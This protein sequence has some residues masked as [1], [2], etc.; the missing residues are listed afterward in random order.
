MFLKV[1]TKCSVAVH[2]IFH[3][4]S[5][6]TVV[7]PV[8]VLYLGVLFRPRGIDPS[9]RRPAAMTGREDSQVLMIH[10]RVFQEQQSSQNVSSQRNAVLGLPAPFGSDEPYMERLSDQLIQESTADNRPIWVHKIHRN[11]LLQPHMA[12]I[13]LI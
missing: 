11:P 13:L 3:L 12:V 10:R 9:V 4:L 8:F 2:V 7:L 1:K 6:I 5:T